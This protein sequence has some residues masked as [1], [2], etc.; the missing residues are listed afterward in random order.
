MFCNKYV[1]WI[2]DGKSSKQITIS[3][4]YIFILQHHF[5]TWLWAFCK[6]NQEGKYKQFFLYFTLPNKLYL[7]HEKHPC[8]E[9][10]SDY[11]R[12]VFQKSILLSCC[13]PTGLNSSSPEPTAR[14]RQHWEIQHP[15]LL[16]LNTIQNNNKKYKY[17]G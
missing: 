6:A 4:Y 10:H 13:L 15:E 2:T 1:L 11:I 5:I 3:W 17:N 9:M 7:H 8:K 14:Q 16:Y 12:I